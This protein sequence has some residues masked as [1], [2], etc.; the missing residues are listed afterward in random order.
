MGVWSQSEA[1]RELSLFVA[2]GKRDS[3]HRRPEL[4]ATCHINSKPTGW[5]NGLMKSN[6]PRKLSTL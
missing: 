1:I 2:L 6:E 3:D 4:L 5:Q